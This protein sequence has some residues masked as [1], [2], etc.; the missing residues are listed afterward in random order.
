M[1]AIILAAG[2]GSR[3]QPITKTRSKP[4][5]PVLGKPI[6]QRVMENLASGGLDDFILVVN[7]RDSEIKEYFSNFGISLKFVEQSKQLGTG[8]A[9]QQAA[10]LIKEDFVLSA[11]DYLVT[12][13]DVR[14]LVTQFAERKGLGG[15]LSLIRI[16]VEDSFKTGIVTLEGERVTNIVEKPPPDQARS[17]ISSLPLYC[18]SKG[19]LDYLP[20]MQISTR[21][22]YELQE[23][24]QSMISEGVEVSGVFFQ[25][26]LALT[27][28]ED[29]LELN[30]HLLRAGAEEPHILS[31]KVGRQTKLTRPLRI[32]ERV[33]I[34]S[35][36]TIGP[37][38]YIERGAQIG[39][40]VHLQKAVVLRGAVIP[41]GAQIS[42][43]VIV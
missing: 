22:E 43:Q 10:P 33:T 35:G 34:G 4:M 32:E 2:R 42:G 14:G 20:R 23:A 36:C 41:D 6:V 16:P 31:S 38:V 1:Q 19:I 25:S 18:F 30:L 12:Q 5:L 39:D 40:R 7:P 13:E 9:L 37:E 3:L 21:G 29:L 11:S 27:T 17:N 26:Y 24:I 15:L 28:A 8:D